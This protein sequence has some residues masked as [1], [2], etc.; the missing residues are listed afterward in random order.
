MQ[1]ITR[2]KE[3]EAAEERNHR[4]IAMGEMAAK[5]VHE[6]RSPL[7]SIELYASMLARD[8]GGTPNAEMAEGISS[9]I[10]SLNNVLTNML[11]FAKPRQ[12]ALRPSEVCRAIEGTVYLL[13]PM[14]ESHGL[15]HHIFGRLGRTRAV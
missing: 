2:L 8:L 15:T 14:A 3:L 12:A 9:G 10:H 6:I 5:I 13:K 7:C 4:L 11:F 1:D